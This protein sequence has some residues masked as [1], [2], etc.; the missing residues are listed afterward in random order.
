MKK[1]NAMRLLDT[2]S[3]PYTPFEYSVADG[4][5]DG[6]SVAAKTGQD[7]ARVFKTLVLRGASGGLYV[8]CLPVSQALPLK[9]AAGAAGEKNMALLPLH[10]LLPATG[11]RR[12]G[13]SPLAMKRA[14]PVF[15]E[16]SAF[17]FAS[18]LV[19]GGQVGLQIQ[20]SAASLQKAANATVF[21]LPGGPCVCPM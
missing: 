9:T 17:S 18:I 13:C 10:E 14:Y 4:G 5:L 19:S 6:P 2:L 12:G 7:P 15:L 16:Q 20:L 8:F 3:L 21:S 11:Y 1:T